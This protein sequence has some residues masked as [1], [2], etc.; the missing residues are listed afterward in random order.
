MVGY[1]PELDQDRPEKIDM[2]VKMNAMSGLS[3]TLTAIS[4]LVAFRFVC[5]RII[6]CLGL[7]RL[8]H[9]LN[10]NNGPDRR[11]VCAL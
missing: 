2:R 6:T 4:I 9:I 1:D 5:S 11:G 10:Y 7:S 3:I 8:Q